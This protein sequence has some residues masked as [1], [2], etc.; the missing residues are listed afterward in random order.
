MSWE[1]HGIRI[2]IKALF[3]KVNYI[4][5]NEKNVNLILFFADISTMINSIGNENTD[6]NG[7]KLNKNIDLSLT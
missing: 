3:K 6:V 7:I 1:I 4:E 2:L 5:I